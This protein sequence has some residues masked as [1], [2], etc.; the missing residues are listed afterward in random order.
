MT[1]W[2]LWG[3][4][5]KAT[6]GQKAPTIVPYRNTLNRGFYTK[7]SFFSGYELGDYVVLFLGERYFVHL[8]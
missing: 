3:S 2:S 4:I 1:K 7:I 6:R 5:M 8:V